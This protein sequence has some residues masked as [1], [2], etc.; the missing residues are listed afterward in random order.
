VAG[1][2]P[3]WLGLLAGMAGWVC[4]LVWLFFYWLGWLVGLKASL[5][6]YQFNGGYLPNSLA[7][8]K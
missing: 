5:P 2:L 6:F 8:E 7:A 1:L 3:S 4:W